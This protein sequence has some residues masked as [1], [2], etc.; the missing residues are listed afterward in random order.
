MYQYW[1]TNDNKRPT[2]M[3]DVN[4]NGGNGVGELYGNALNFHKVA[5]SAHLKLL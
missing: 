4:N 5:F 1:F 2:P 3:L